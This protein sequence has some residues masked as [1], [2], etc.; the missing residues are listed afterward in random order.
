MPR[1]AEYDPNPNARGV[2]L[3][4]NAIDPGTTEAHGTGATVCLSTPFHIILESNK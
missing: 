1:G 3:S 4:H 2:P